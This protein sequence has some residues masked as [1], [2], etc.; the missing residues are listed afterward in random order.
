MT[1]TEDKQNKVK[2]ARVLEKA[3]WHITKE[4][5]PKKLESLFS[6]NKDKTFNIN[7]LDEDLD[8]DGGN[9]L[10]YCIKEGGRI[11]KKTIS[12]EC[13]ACCS[14]LL[15][16]GAGVNHK[17][18]FGRTALFWSVGFKCSQLV[19]LL[20]KFKADPTVEDQDGKN[21]LEVAIQLG[22]KECVQAI[23]EN[24]PQKVI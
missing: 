24:E 2:I 5:K 18:H 10:I 8:E 23:L 4:H 19:E 20:M 16:N 17:D 12:K 6:E 9:V 14:L 7:A 11:G 21:A 1:D 13:I 3:V 15:E 22:A